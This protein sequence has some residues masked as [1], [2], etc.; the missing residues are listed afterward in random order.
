MMAMGQERIVRVM[1]GYI[2]DLDSGPRYSD[3]T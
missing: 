3:I 2:E 1:F